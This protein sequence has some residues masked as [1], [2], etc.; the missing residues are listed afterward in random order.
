[1]ITGFTAAQE[2]AFD[3]SVARAW[4]VADSAGTQLTITGNNQKKRTSFATTGMGN[5]SI[6]TAAA[7]TAGTRTL[8]A[9]PMLTGLGRTPAAA[10]LNDQGFESVLDL[11]NGQD[12]PIILATNEGVVVRNTIA[13]GAGGTVRMLA[14]MGWNELDSYP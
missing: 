13:L 4:T 7:V 12:Y 1:M 9:N 8:D 14:E 5:I 2:L 3:A 11:T 10:S 6:A